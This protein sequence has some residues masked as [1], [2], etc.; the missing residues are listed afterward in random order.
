MH[1]KRRQGLAVAW[2]LSQANHLLRRMNNHVA[3]DTVIEIS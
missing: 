1:R 3:F 2:L